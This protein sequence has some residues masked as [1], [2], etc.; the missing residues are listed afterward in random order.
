[1]GTKAKPFATP[2]IFL[3]I[4]WMR[5]YQGQV[6][7]DKIQGGGAYVDEHGFGGEIFNFKAFKARVYGYGQ[8]PGGA[9]FKID[10][11]GAS[12]IDKCVS[13]VLVIWVARSPQGGNYVVG[14]YDNATVFREWQES[15]ATANRHHGKHALGFNVRASHGDATLLPS[16]ERLFLIPRGKG[17]MGQA[18]VW[19]ADDPEQHRGIRIDILRYISTRRLPRM[20]SRSRGKRP[21]ATDPLRRQRVERTA[22]EATTTRYTEFGYVVDS[23][24]KDNLGWD[25]NAVR[26]QR[27]LLLEVKGLSHHDIQVE[28][29]PNEY[30][31]MKA[32]RQSYRVCVVTGALSSPEL[33]VFAFSPETRQWEDETGRVLRIDESVAARCRALPQP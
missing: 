19:Y 12:S 11:L 22:I 26:G 17:G 28:L 16:D 30:K 1:M 7:G 23:V 21:R 14:W 31:A 32:N 27:R 8:P 24:E 6:G 29:T 5:R 3:R 10:R 25:L 13:G 2:M 33:T 18:N 4:G 20:A 15:P 9:G